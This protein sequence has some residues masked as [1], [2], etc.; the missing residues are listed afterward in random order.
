MMT[1]PARRRRIFYTYN[2]RFFCIGPL[3]TYLP[4]SSWI[5]LSMQ[6]GYPVIDC[7]RRSFDMRSSPLFSITSAGL[8]NEDTYTSQEE[9]GVR[10]N[11]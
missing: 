9:Y 10:V 8:D 3:D 5:L 1:I 2:T 6:Y 4:A 7:S 11:M